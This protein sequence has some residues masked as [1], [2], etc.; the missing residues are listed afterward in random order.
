M[1]LK[2]LLKEKKDSVRKNL[3]GSLFDFYEIEEFGEVLSF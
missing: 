2:K 3:S 1:S